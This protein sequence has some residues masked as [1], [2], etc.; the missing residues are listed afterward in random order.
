MLVGGLINDLEWWVL[1]NYFSRKFSTNGNDQM[2]TVLTNNDQ[3]TTVLD[4][5]VHNFAVDGSSDD[6]D[7]PI[8]VRK[9]KQL[10]F[11]LN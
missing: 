11:F 8:K 7:V 10:I 5:N 2:T 9:L 6:L 3:M 4:E 1:E